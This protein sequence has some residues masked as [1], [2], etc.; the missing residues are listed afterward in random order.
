MWRTSARVSM[1][2]MPATP[3]LRGSRRATAA[4][5]SCTAR[6]STPCT[7]KPSHE[8]ARRLHVFGVDPDVADLRIGH[9]DHL[10]VVRR[11]GED[12][13]VAGH[14]GVE[15]DL[16]ARL[17][18]R[19][20]ALPSKTVPSAN[21][22]SAF[23]RAPRRGLPPA[24]LCV[25]AIRPP[26]DDGDDGL[27]AQLHA[28]ERR[29]ARL[30]SE[31]VPDRRSSA[32]PDR[33]GDVGD[34]ADR[35]RPPLTPRM[36]AGWCSCAATSVPT[37]DASPRARPQRQRQRRLQADDAVGGLVE[38]DVLLVAVVR[39]VIGGDGVDGA[40]GQPLRAPRRRPSACAAAGSSCALVS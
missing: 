8:R 34:V 32:A 16:A 11:I 27:P 40:V 37:A 36:R 4:R 39:R 35:Q 9:G 19:A 1:P 25:R 14:G 13:L 22:S 26:A 21:A 30:R 31:A 5:A 12:L 17:A 6:P 24:A 20:E 7:M 28:V 15:H 10:A 3:S 18:D 2:S 29:V 38:L 23:M 33:R